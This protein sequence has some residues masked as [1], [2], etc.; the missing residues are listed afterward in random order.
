MKSA[1]ELALDR[2]GGTI[3]ELSDEQKGKIAEIDG[4]MKAKLAEAEI[5]KN[6]R[7]AEAA[8]DIMRQEEILKDYA[9][10]VASVTSHSEQEKEKVR[11]EK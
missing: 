5:A 8:G 6:K 1:F 2:S 7:Y 3:R 11:E 10:E 9:V 4:R